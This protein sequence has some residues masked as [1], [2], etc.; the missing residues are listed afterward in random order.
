MMDQNTFQAVMLQRIDLLTSMVKNNTVLVQWLVSNAKL[1]N[2]QQ[3]FRM[4]ETPPLD[5]ALVHNLLLN[6]PGVTHHHQPT[7][8][9]AAAITA[10]QM[11]EKSLQMNSI[12]RL[13][14]NSA[15][16][17]Q[18]NPIIKMEI[19]FP[20]KTESDTHSDQ[21]KA[22][23]ST[24][25]TA[26]TGSTVKTEETTTAIAAAVQE[27]QQYSSNNSNETTVPATSQSLANNSDKKQVMDQPSSAS[28][29][30]SQS[31]AVVVVPVPN[32]PNNQKVNT[33]ASIYQCESLLTP[34]LFTT[35]TGEHC[36]W[37]TGAFF[38][39]KAKL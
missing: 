34:N 17:Y 19:D 6:L 27:Q 36:D 20:I 10:N 14:S 23:E 29:A 22:V 38:T 25:A 33:C 7:S 24:A 11:D 9:A 32:D 18:A 31:A 39:S 15:T 2:Q 5:E 4:A 28:D 1:L 12:T 13:S 8:A 26:N 16:N 30:P 35:W 3:E 21:L 37:I